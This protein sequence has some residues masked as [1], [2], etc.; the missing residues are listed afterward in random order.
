MRLRNKFLVLIN[1]IALLFV[2]TSFMNKH[3]F[4]FRNGAYRI[5]FQEENETFDGGI[6]DYIQGHQGYYFTGDKDSLENEHC[7]EVIEKFDW[8]MDYDNNQLILTNKVVLI[9]DSCGGSYHKDVPYIQYFDIIHESK[10]SL[11]TK[12]NKDDVHGKITYF[13]EDESLY[14]WVW[15]RKLSAAEKKLIKR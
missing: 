14:I 12:H 13:N 9:K 11:V 6:S 3:K 15:D 2:V 7:E 10:D 4:H 5:Y 8:E 1:L